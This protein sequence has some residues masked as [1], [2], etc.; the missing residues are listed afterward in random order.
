MAAIA[1]RCVEITEKDA[2]TRSFAIRLSNDVMFPFGINLLASSLFC[3]LYSG[4]R[5]SRDFGL[6]AGRQHYAPFLE[7]L[8]GDSASIAGRNLA[9]DSACRHCLQHAYYARAETRPRRH[10]DAPS[11]F[12]RRREAGRHAY[13]SALVSRRPYRRHTPASGREKA[14]FIAFE[15]C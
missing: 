3:T 4:R 8:L 5:Y 12:A 9:F 1:A 11:A 14:Y 13:R 6:I 15:A 2:S 7:A 10:D